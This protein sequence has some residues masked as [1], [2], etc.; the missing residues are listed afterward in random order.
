MLNPLCFNDIDLGL[1][2]SAMTGNSNKHFAFKTLVTLYCLH[3]LPFL[4]F[5]IS[6]SEVCEHLVT[7]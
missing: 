4:P 5:R 7:Q 6:F 2:P 3:L 1:V